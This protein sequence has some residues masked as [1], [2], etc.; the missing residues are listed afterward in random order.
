MKS[1]IYFMT[2]AILI[3]IFSL[4]AAFAPIVTDGLVSYWTFDKA[5]IINK[6][7]KDVW[8]DNNGKIIG[9]PKVVSGQVGEALK[10]DGV[11][12]FV[13]LT[14]LG[15]FGEQFGTASF[16]AWIKTTNKTDWMTLINT[17]GAACPNWGIELN[18]NNNAF[19]FEIKERMLYHYI[20]IGGPKR[21]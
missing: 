3:G 17:H 20:G 4:N 1:G 21:M 5:H 15:D 14:A 16:E 12:D 13:D 6:T 10:F 2:S 19:G 11:D 8:G 7:A 18:G 9:N